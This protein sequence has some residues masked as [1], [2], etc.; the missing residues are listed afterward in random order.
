MHTEGEE[1]KA[2]IKKQL[3][4]YFSR[5]NISKDA[6]LVS[7]MDSQMYVP[8]AVIQQVRTNENVRSVQANTHNSVAVSCSSPRFG[9]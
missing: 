3:E 4:Y 5:E 2:A 8:I 6:Y 9:D 7:Q 1:L